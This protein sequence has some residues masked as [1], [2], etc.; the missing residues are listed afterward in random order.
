MIW[1]FKRTTALAVF[2]Y[3]LMA[4]F[5]I[6]GLAF[7]IP[8]FPMM[9]LM[10]LIPLGIEIGALFWSV[11]LFSIHMDTANTDAEGFLAKNQ[12]LYR[13][14]RGKLK[15]V[16]LENEI[17]MLISYRRIR[18]AESRLPELAQQIMPSDTA[19][20]FFYLTILMELDTLKRNY[21]HMDAYISEK[22]ILLDRMG[23][24]ISQ[25]NKARLELSFELSVIS[26]E[27]YSRSLQRLRNED[28]ALAQRYLG[29]IMRSLDSV[30]DVKISKNY[31]IMELNYEA[32]T[33]CAVMGQEQQAREYFERV[34]STGYIFPEVAA[35]AEYLRTGDPE[36][37][38]ARP[39]FR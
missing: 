7:D 29:L 39:E 15:P 36:P 35:A 12:Q 19:N 6:A 20:Q 8:F 17:T 23:S 5:F 37:L 25:K 10:F 13:K 21:T 34:V 32:G 3:V 4:G 2:G 38:L 24:S 27:F 33:A 28:I 11:K 14:V 9:A 31:S 16:I 26:A 18:D 30:K 1:I 22:R